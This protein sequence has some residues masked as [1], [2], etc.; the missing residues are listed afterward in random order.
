MKSIAIITASLILSL[1]S[2]AAHA[3]RQGGGGLIKAFAS[4]HHLIEFSVSDSDKFDAAHF[5][6]EAILYRGSED[7]TLYFEYKVRE[8]GETY[9][10][11]VAVTKNQLGLDY[12]F[13]IQSLSAS[14]STG[15]WKPVL[16]KSES[17]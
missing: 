15:V 14:K 11:K 3:D 7:G 6:D 12:P 4:A 5:S 8:V 9:L 13:L 17:R 2:F 16:E 10:A 1:L